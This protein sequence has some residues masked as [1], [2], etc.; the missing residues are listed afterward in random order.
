MEW[1]REFIGFDHLVVVGIGP[2]FCALGVSSES[3]AAKAQFSGFA[4]FS[5][6]II[7]YNVAIMISANRK[8]I[9]ISLTARIIWSSSLCCRN[10]CWWSRCCFC[11]KRTLI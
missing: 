5:N 10:G 3:V 8:I 1:S 2:T 9:Q 11:G 6:K 7:K 4:H